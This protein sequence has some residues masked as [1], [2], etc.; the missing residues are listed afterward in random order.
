VT[1]D[2]QQAVQLAINLLHLSSTKAVLEAA[3]L[4]NMSAKLFT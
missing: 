1:P 4:G 2:Q 3:K